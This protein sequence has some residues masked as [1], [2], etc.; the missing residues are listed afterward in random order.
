MAPDHRVFRKAGRVRRRDDLPGASELV[1]V[2]SAKRRE[3]YPTTIVD[4][5]VDVPKADDPTVTSVRILVQVVMRV[6]KA[7]RQECSDQYCDRN[8]K[9]SI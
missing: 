2:H 6:N 7:L 9:N 3:S 4:H 1:L 8:S 5:Y